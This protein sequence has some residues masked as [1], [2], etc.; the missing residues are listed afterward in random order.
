MSKYSIHKEITWLKYL[1]LPASPV[2]IPPVNAVLKT[3]HMLT[4]TYSDLNEQ[5]IKLTTYDDELIRLTIYS[6]KTISEETPCLIYYYGSAYFMTPNYHHKK[7]AMVYAKEANCKV[8]FVNYRLSPVHPF[9]TPF[10]DCYQA[11][12]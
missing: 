4:K 6:P 11:A 12:E 3:L 10:L 9:P 2:I 1:T 5:H 7:W 8:V